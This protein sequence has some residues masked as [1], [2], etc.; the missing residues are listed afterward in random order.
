MG[1]TLTG[2][3]QWFK[4]VN[5]PNRR[6]AVESLSQRLALMNAHKFAQLMAVWAVPASLVGPNGRVVGV[7]LPD[8]SAAGRVE[9]GAG[10][11]GRGVAA[12]DRAQE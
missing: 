11:A 10:R 4:G 8:R 7:F 2:L 1:R 3:D 9:T 5:N 12:A 6:A